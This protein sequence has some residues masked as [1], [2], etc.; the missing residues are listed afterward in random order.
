ML[1]ILLHCS[2]SRIFSSSL[3]L[4]SKFFISS[5]YSQDL[6][7]SLLSLMDNFT[8]PYFLVFTMDFIRLSCFT[9]YIPPPCHESLMIFLFLAITREIY[10]FSLQL[11]T[12]NP[13]LRWIML[14]I[15]WAAFHAI[16][17]LCTF[18]LPCFSRIILSTFYVLFT[19][20]PF[21]L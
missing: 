6:Y 18:T 13:F 7:F 20:F 8:L 3:Q 21:S 5:F 19:V 15:S 12:N 14:T 11:F 2:Y 4:F 16:H 10:Y 9:D 17:G 1:Y